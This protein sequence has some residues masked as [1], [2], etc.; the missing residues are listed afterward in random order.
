MCRYLLFLKL[1]LSVQVWKAVCMYISAT[2]LFS[3]TFLF[4]SP[5]L[6]LHSYFLLSVSHSTSLPR[7]RPAFLPCVHI[8]PSGGTDQN[9]SVEIQE[10]K[11][12]LFF[13]C[14][15]PGTNRVAMVQ[16]QGT[17]LGCDQ[18]YSH[19]FFLYLRNFSLPVSQ[20]FLFIYS[21][22]SYYVPVF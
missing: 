10:R 18:S 6:F 20:I 16:N 19:I 8:I 4:Q 1:V 15:E 5:I 21:V 9:L 13:C 3:F 22:K 14:P 11:S 2:L 12:H 7:L 17:Q